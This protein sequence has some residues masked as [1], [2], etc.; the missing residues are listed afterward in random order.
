MIDLMAQTRIGD[1][2]VVSIE[3][4]LQLTE[5]GDLAIVDHLDF[6]IQ[7]ASKL[8]LTEK[9]ENIWFPELGTNLFTLMSQWGNSFYQTALLEEDILDT[10]AQYHYI[11]R[12]SDDPTQKIQQVVSYEVKE[13]EN[14]SSI[15]IINITI[16]T[17]ANKIAPLSL[18]FGE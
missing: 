11:S 2:L 6:L 15:V 7:D 10:L 14:N 1:K 4:D 16:V 17:Q 13:D 18:T 9:G 12:E 3:N 8:F 5:N